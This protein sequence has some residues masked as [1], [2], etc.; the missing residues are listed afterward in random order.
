ML[1]QFQVYS[2][3]IQLYVCVCMYILVQILLHYK[4]LQDTE[5]IERFLLPF[6]IRHVC[7]QQILSAFVFLGMYFFSF[8]FQRQ[9]SWTQN[10]LLTVFLLL[11]SHS[12]TFW[13][14]VSDESLA[15]NYIDARLYL[16]IHLLFLAFKIFCLS[17]AFSSL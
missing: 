12:T 11:N 13:S 17:S 7:Q 16:M 2:K 3:V 4:L 15:T 8:H 14:L 5:Y 1:C 10:S 6:I 9:F